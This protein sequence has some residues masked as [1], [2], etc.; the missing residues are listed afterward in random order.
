MA[1]ST[2]TRPSTRR[3]DERAPSA[4]IRI[5]ACGSSASRSAS[6][7][8]FSATTVSMIAI[9]GATVRAGAVTIDE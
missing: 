6:P 8:T 4:A 2:T 1:N 7:S 3:E 5:R 9:P